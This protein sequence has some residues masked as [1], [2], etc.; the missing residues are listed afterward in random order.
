MIRGFPKCAHCGAIR[1]R[2]HCKN[3]QCKWSI[4]TECHWI[5]DRKTTVEGG[6]QA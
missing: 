1:W 4:C 2:E 5:T 3:G 6:R